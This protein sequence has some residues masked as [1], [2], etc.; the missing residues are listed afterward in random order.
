MLK[1]LKEDKIMQNKRVVCCPFCSKKLTRSWEETASQI[2][3][4]EYQSCEEHNIVSTYSWPPSVKSV[5]VRTEDVMKLFPREEQISPEE[6]GFLYRYELDKMLKHESHNINW[7]NS[8]IYEK[9][10]AHHIDL[11]KTHFSFINFE[12]YYRLLK[13]GAK[14]AVA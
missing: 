8:A 13:Q 7:N 12:I 11:N 3:S 1:A 5:D 14:H 4:E 10:K 6:I 9:C 2:P